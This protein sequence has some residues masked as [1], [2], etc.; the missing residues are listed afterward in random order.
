[1]TSAKA[2]NNN[3]EWYTPLHVIHKV[4][5]VFGKTIDLDPCST[6]EANLRIKADKFFN[7]EINCLNTEW[8]GKVFM[9][10]PYSGNLLIHVLKKAVQQYRKGNIEEIII[11]TNSG[12]DTKWNQEL[13]NGIQAYTVGRIKFIYPDGT[14][15][16]TPS[17]GQV[18]TY[19][20]DDTEKFI[21][22]FTK[23]DFT[24]IPNLKLGERNA[25]D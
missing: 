5:E 12:T 16:G 17:R 24:W 11:L 8:Y 3:N 13:K 25:D 21:E 19:Y 22:V 9:N 23:D 20:G 6:R 4:R 14:Q 2:E 10:P 1:M 15:A 18:F 7:K